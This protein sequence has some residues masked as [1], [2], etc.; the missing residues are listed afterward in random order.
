[1]IVGHTLAYQTL[2]TAI[3]QQRHHGFLLAGPKGVG[4]ATTARTVAIAALVK[5][6]QQQAQIV[7]RQCLSGAYPNYIYLTKRFDDDGKPKNEITVEQVRAL[8]NGLKFKAAY[9]APRFVIIDAIDDLNRTAANALLKMLEEPPLNTFF[10]LVCHALGGLLPTIRSRCLVLNFK[11]LAEADLERVVTKAGF[12]MDATIAALASG[13]AGHY[14]QIQ[15][16]GGV[17]LLRSIEQLLKISNLSDLKT[18]IQA[19]LKIGDATF[20]LQ[21]LHQI[22]YQKALRQ[23]DVYA[24]SAQAVERFTRFTQSTHLDAA[25]RTVAAVLLA[26]NPSQQQVI[27]G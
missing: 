18:A 22:L 19:I 25:Q 11:R 7:E 15:Q 10:L 3:H 9:A 20:I 21:I 27:Y 24:N 23:P 14:C 26:Q 5:A 17:E 6:S 16:A 4:K 8:L 1:M 2:E 12:S 13:A